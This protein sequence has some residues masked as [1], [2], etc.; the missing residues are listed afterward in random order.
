[1]LS[2]W[3]LN[4]HINIFPPFGSFKWTRGSTC[5]NSLT[6]LPL[7]DTMGQLFPRF[8][9]WTPPPCVLPPDEK[10]NQ[11]QH[12]GGAHQRKRTHAVLQH[13][14]DCVDCLC[15]ST[16]T[17]LLAILCPYKELRQKASAEAVHRVISSSWLQLCHSFNYMKLWDKQKGSILAVSKNRAADTRTHS[18]GR[19]C[20]CDE[21]CY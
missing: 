5:W 3:G 9:G 7:T 14:S 17:E 10:R 19:S 13:D 4:E 21:H 20:H 1:M 11:R 18:Y 15:V 12:C 8:P 2:D 16:H 6:S